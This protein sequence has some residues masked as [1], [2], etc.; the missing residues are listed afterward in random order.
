MFQSVTVIRAI[1]C[2]SP[3]MDRPCKAADGSGAAG[4]SKSYWLQP[5][6][7]SSPESGKELATSIGTA[8]SQDNGDSSLSSPR[9]PIILFQRWLEKRST[10]RKEDRAYSMSGIFDVQMPLL[11][12]EGKDKAFSRLQRKIAKS[13]S[14]ITPHDSQYLL[15]VS[16]Q[17]TTMPQI[18]DQT[19]TDIKIPDSTPTP[20]NGQGSMQLMQ[21]QILGAVKSLLEETKHVIS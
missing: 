21:E 12:G 2:H 15:S 18:K 20:P 5:V 1:S 19:Q 9:K 10:T 17:S 8:T 3:N 4:H 16:S 11:Y 7:S 13:K 14:V 6:S